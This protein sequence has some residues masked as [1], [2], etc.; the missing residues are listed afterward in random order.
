[1]CSILSSFLP[2]SPPIVFSWA[3][4]VSSVTMNNKGLHNYGEPSTD[5]LS[6]SIPVQTAI[7]HRFDSNKHLDR[8]GKLGTTLAH[9]YMFQ[10]YVYIPRVGVLEEYEPHDHPHH[11][12]YPQTAKLIDLFKY[13]LLTLV[14]DSCCPTYSL[15]SSLEPRL[16]L[17]L[18]AAPIVLQLY[19]SLGAC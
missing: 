14:G 6:L 5:I 9:S 19:A 1:M 13:G 2:F 3:S 15:P 8:P 17:K 7:K 16:P 18:S 12:R 11:Q 10:Y 4:A